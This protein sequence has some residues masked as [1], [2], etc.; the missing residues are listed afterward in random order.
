MSWLFEP[1]DRA[2][3]EVVVDQERMI[4]V[5]KTEEFLSGQVPETKA[6]VK[7]LIAFKV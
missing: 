2:S 3:G 7:P 5:T 6:R 1:G 4:L